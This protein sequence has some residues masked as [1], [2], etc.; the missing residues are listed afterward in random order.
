M[1]VAKAQQTVNAIRQ[2]ST[3]AIHL[4]ISGSS[5]TF[6]LFPQISAHRNDSSYGLTETIIAKYKFPINRACTI[7]F[8]RQALRGRRRGNEIIR[9]PHGFD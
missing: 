8:V 2:A 4:F 5:S 3:K 9:Y 1:I 7:N 6:C